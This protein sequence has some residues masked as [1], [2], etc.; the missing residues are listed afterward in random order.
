MF[1]ITTS[2]GLL[3]S[4]EQV[5][6][7]ASLSSEEKTTLFSCLQENVTALPILP[8]H[9]AV[10]NAAI[11]RLIDDETKDNDRRDASARK[12]TKQRRKTKRVEKPTEVASGRAEEGS[13]APGGKAEGVEDEAEDTGRAAEEG[14][15][16]G[17]SEAEASEDEETTSKED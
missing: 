10:V 7:S 5:K 9:A 17:T 16:G 4:A 12:A 15:D 8:K 2:I 1:N 13:E 14:S 6:A 11:Q 3:V